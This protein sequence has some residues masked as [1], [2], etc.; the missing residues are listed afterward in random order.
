M[1][2][3]RKPD[4]SGLHER[5]EEILKKIPGDTPL[6][7]TEFG[8][9]SVLKYYSALQELWSENYHAAVVRDYIRESEKHRKIVGTFVF[10]FTDYA[11]PSKPVTGRWNGKI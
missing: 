8:A 4:V 7:L 9:D 5:I 3:K 6:L 2:E 10:A 11:D 1:N